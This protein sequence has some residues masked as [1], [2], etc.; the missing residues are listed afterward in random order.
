MRIEVIEGSIVDVHVDAI[1]N[2]ANLMG[3]MGGGVAKAI[4]QAGGPAIETEAMA[5]APIRIGQ[6]VLTT[7]GNLSARHVIHAPTMVKPA[8]R[9]NIENVR[10]ATEAA[11]RCAEKARLRSIAFPGMGT[12]VG[13]V[14]P[15][16]AARCM[17]DALHALDIVNLQRVVL[18]DRNPDMVAAFEHAVQN[19]KGIRG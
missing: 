8:E 7:A 16:A 4:K 11:A 1:V 2:P 13:R 10:A 17:V 5:H 15:E 9:T 19:R 14:E 18:V 3:R 6:A 12:G